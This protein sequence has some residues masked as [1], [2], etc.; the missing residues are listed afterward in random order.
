MKKVFS[1]LFFFSA[2]MIH[3]QDAHFTQFENAPFFINPA[4]AGM[5]ESFDFRANMATRNQWRAIAKPSMNTMWSADAQLLRHRG[6]EPAKS[7]LGAGFVFGMSNFGENK[8]KQTSASIALS[9]ITTVGERKFLSVGL[10][11]GRGAVRSDLTGDS[12]DS[13]YNGFKYSES[14]GNN[15]PLAVAYKG[16]YW[17]FST[18]INF[19]AYNKQKGNATNIGVSYLHFT[20]PVLKNDQMKGE[21]D[22]RM[23][24][25]ARTEFDLN[26]KNTHPV[27]LIP[28]V[29]FAMQGVHMEVQ[30]GAS[31]FFV[32]QPISSVLN[33]RHKQGIE[34]GAM[35]RYGDAVGLLGAYKTDNLRIGLCYDITISALGESAKRRGG[36][37]LSL[38]Y[39]AFN[40]RLRESKQI[41]D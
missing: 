2:L 28:R 21:L 29:L 41:Y 14:L 23:V 4:S 12:W 34:V 11:A 32:T 13:Q 5:F 39:Y 6:G 18:G 20:N 24:F 35:Y 1:I 8:T 10:S 17:D 37:E 22:A 31:V 40:K 16:T 30:M 9:G 7:F 26:L 19:L 25:H 36:A 3:A 15:E 33:Y 38:V 27:Y